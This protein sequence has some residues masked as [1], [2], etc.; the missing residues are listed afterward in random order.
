VL[1]NFVV[2]GAAKSGT[3]SLHRYLAAHPD[4][5]M[6][7]TKELNFFV[8]VRGQAPDA[9]NGPRP[10]GG[11][12]AQGIEWYER[13]FQAANGARAVGEASPRYS[14]HPYLPGV[15]ERMAEVI[16]NAKLVYVVRD[17]ITR[18]VSHYVQRTRRRTLHETRPLEVALTEEGGEYLSTSRYAHQIEQFLQ[19][20]DHRR[21]LVVL[22]EKLRSDRDTTMSRILEFLGVDA[23]W[24]D[25]A[26]A[27][28]HLV[29][30]WGPPRAITRFGMSGSWWNRAVPKLP[31]RVKHLGRRVSHR[32]LP[33]VRLSPE[34]RSNLVELLHDDVARL[35]DYVD[36]EDFDGWGIA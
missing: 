7:Q 22:S 25:Q 36:D 32:P 35:R 14:M 8:S 10:R 17:P 15:P 2:I 23:D 4:V 34:L 27:E 33:E 18:M 20:F 16:P 19:H 12:W 5:Y 21:L 11:N 6:S 9:G 30:A 13:Q 24:R 3:T 31:G 28:E 26:L 29:S 1:P